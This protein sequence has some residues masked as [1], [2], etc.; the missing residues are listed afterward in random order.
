MNQSPSNEFELQLKDYARQLSG[1]DLNALGSIYDHAGTRL[2]RYALFLVK[3]RTEADDIVQ[4]T[5]L[6]L[7]RNP[8]KLVRSKHPVAYL[9]RILRNEAYTI[10]YRRKPFEHCDVLP[11]IPARTSLQSDTWEI[12]EAVH[13]ALA[14]L[15]AI[16]A[17]VITLHLW[18][19]LT[20]REVSEITNESINTVASRYR[21]GIEKLSKTLR[22]FDESGRPTWEDVAIKFQMQR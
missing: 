19:N 15:P 22:S 21:Y 2:L 17:E 7:A 4:A 3:D 14:E 20:F 1:G 18:E 13:E 11:L 16:Q 10:L 8:K 6:K 5:M 12:T 9:F